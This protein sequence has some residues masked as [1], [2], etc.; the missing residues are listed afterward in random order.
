VSEHDPQPHINKSLAL[1]VKRNE[2]TE[3]L[4]EVYDPE[5]GMNVVELGLIRRID[6]TDKSCHIEMILTTPFCPYAPA[7][8]RE[9]RQTAEIASGLHARVEMGAEM[10]DPSMMEEGA[11]DEWGLF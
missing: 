7:L 4:R 3:A 1:D 6:L 2:I 10:W 9:V 8:L 11:R 5:L